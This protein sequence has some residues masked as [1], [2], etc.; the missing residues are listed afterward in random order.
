MA[1]TDPNGEFVMVN[2]IPFS[3]FWLLYSIVSFVICDSNNSAIHTVTKQ[4]KETLNKS[5][6]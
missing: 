1:K 4:T 6:N 3:K 5:R 2:A